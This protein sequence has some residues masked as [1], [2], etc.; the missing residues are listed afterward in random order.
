MNEEKIENWEEKARE[1]I[2]NLNKE[3][4]KNLKDNEALFDSMVYYT[5]PKA[6]LEEIVA[7]VSRDPDTLLTEILF[8]EFDEEIIEN[9]I[10]KLDDKSPTGTFIIKFWGKDE[11]TSYEY[12]EWDFL[13]SMNYEVEQ[14]SFY[15]FEKALRQIKRVK[16]VNKQLLQKII[17]LQ[18]CME[19]GNPAGG[20]AY[21]ADIKRILYKEIDEVR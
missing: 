15:N 18:G 8:T 3:T 16:E 2:E 12:D 11:K 17:N 10:E 6:E 20:M 9:Y 7:I 1:D 4:L 5:I 14:L 21:L 19:K 13:T